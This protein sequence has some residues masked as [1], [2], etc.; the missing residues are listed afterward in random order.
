M[1]RHEIAT[2]LGMAAQQLKFIVPERYKVIW[3]F[4]VFGL[5]RE[6]FHFGKTYSFLTRGVPL[7]HINADF[8]WENHA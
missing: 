4:L 5:D 1:I 7:S 8:A 2:N 3:A 6:Y